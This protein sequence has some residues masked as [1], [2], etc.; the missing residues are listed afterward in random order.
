MPDFVA[1]GARLRYEMF[2]ERG[3]VSVLLNGIAM[4]IGHWKP[5]IE[6]LGGNYRFLCHDMRGQTLS[7][8]PKGDY[9]LEGH[10]E[11]LA[12][13]MDHLSI[14]KAHVVG[15][16]YGSEVAMAFAISHPEKCSSLTVIDGVSELDPL[17]RA[18]AESWMATALAD[19]RVFYKVLLPWTYSSSYI[20]ANASILAAREDA[21]AGLPRDWFEGFSELCRSFLAIDLSSKLNRI[22]CPTLVI[23]GD[24]DILKHEGFAAIIAKAIQGSTLKVLPG[25]GHASVIEQPGAVAALVDASISEIE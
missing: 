7:D 4:S 16:S 2:G 18:T 17:L 25:A 3:P 15:T 6:A 19:P 12:A 23:V 24:K 13:L 10:A 21:V 1:K 5:F 14:P 8:K 22:T 20:A 9:S 11:D